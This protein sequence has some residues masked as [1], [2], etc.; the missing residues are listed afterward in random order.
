MTSIIPERVA[1]D[2]EKFQKYFFG[3]Q[4][5]QL[6]SLISV[7]GGLG[8]LLFGYDQGV[9]GVSLLVKSRA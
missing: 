5:K 7:A 2:N 3:A 8:F 4:G 6:R 1:A 9:L